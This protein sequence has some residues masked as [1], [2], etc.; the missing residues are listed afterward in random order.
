MSKADEIFVQNM[1]DILENG[2]W[3]TDLDVRPHWEDGTPAHTVKK[4]CI[5][6]RYNLHLLRSILRDCA[7]NARKV[8]MSSRAS[9]TLRDLS[10][11][12]GYTPTCL[13]F[14]FL[15]REPARTG[16]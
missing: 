3:D 4:F 8:K 15:R 5:V 2:F 6:N 12:V 1:K 13:C 7:R 14:P 16:I 9:R 10:R 11:S